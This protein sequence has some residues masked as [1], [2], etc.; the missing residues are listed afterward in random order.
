MDSKC[1]FQQSSVSRKGINC[2]QRLILLN[3]MVFYIKCCHFP[4][5]NINLSNYGGNFNHLWMCLSYNIKGIMKEL[6]D[7]VSQFYNNF[8]NLIN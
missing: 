2:G 7:C 5:I 6:I 3:S 8:S 4:R 1:K